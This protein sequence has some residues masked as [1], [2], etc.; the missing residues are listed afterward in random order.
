LL[1]KVTDVEAG[2]GAATILRGVSLQVDEGEIVSVLGPNGAG[3]TTTLRAISGVI[4]AR[5]GAVEFDGRKLGNSGIE[6][7]ARAGVGHV[8]EGRGILATLTVE[9]NLTLGTTMRRD[10]APAI[11]ADRDRV[12]DLFPGIV[13]FLKRPASVLSGGQQQMLAIGRSLLARPRLMMI[14]EV[15][16]GLAPVIVESL[17][18]LISELRKGGTTFL[19]VEQSA[20]VL[21]ISD[22]T[23]VLSGGRISLEAKP[24]ELAGSDRLV[25]AYLGAKSG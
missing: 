8:P 19:L 25:R 7:R 1:L 6:D 5:R 21:T 17:L 12:L 13:P 10:G 22:R 3:K 15:S 23:Y 20:S 4:R 18:Q 14:D 11:A 16:F 24:G 2:Y 9:E